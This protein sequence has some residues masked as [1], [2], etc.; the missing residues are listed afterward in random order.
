MAPDR[1]AICSRNGEGILSLS[2]G[3]HDGDIIH[4]TNDEKLVLLAQSTDGGW[5]APTA[6]GQVRS[7]MQVKIDAQARSTPFTNWRYQG[8]A[9][10]SK[11][12]GWR[13]AKIIISSITRMTKRTCE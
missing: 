5:D 10:L 3:D 1:A 8:Y 12:F 2:G 13:L 4:H 7:D 9:R 11:Q 6:L